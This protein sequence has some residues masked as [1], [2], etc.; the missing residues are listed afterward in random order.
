MKVSTVIRER[1]RVG[2]WLFYALPPDHEEDT[3]APDVPPP[4]R[5]SC[6][7]GRDGQGGMDE[8]QTPG[9]DAAPKGCP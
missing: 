7:P 9:S 3:R 2:R 1:R 5:K 8:P 6:P 4:K